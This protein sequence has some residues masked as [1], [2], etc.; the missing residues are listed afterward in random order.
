MN[1]GVSRWAL[2]VKDGSRRMSVTGLGCDQ[3][4]E[5]RKVNSFWKL[6]KARIWTVSQSLP[7]ECSCCPHDS[8]LGKPILHF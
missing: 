3:P 8:S 1:Q 7:R 5:V 2:L 6:G 4:L